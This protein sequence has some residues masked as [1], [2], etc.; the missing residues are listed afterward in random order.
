M[1]TGTVQGQQR[2]RQNIWQGTLEW[3]EKT[4]NPTDTQKQTRHVPC[5]VSTNLKNGKPEL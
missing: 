2:E 5:Q 4:K 1:S 3:L